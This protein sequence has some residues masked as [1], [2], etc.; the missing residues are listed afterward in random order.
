VKAA[1]RK[2]LRRL[3]VEAIRYEPRNFPHL[4]RPQLLRQLGVTL[5]LD[6]GA[7]DGGYAD[8][9]RK[10]GYEGRIVS[11]EP[12]RDSFAA[13][14]R[15]AAADLDWEPRR[16]ALGREPDTLELG[17]AGNRQSSSLLPMLE[18]HAKAE[19]GSAYVGAEAVPVVRLDD[20][21]PELG[22][23]EERAFLKVDVQGYELAVL[24]GARATLAAVQAVE[25]ELSAVPLYSGQALLPEVLS[26]LQH[27]GFELIGLETTFRD[28]DTGDLLQLNGLLRRP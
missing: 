15:R 19:P 8:V 22:V 28:R 27:A 16:L 6:V 4:R 18:R 12:E 24:E 20:L 17:V 3:G 7:S 21:A 5:V 23:A 9:L 14:E 13:L 10:A 25:V 2:L 26:L 1:A 11:F